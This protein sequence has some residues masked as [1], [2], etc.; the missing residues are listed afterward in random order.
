VT[1][2]NRTDGGRILTV[3][4]ALSVHKRGGR[5]LVLAPDGTGT[6]APPRP[7]IDNAMVK[8]IARAFRWRK[9]LETGVHASIAEIATAEKINDSYVGRVLRLSLLAPEIVE[10]IVE[11]R[12][13]EKLQLAHLLRPFSIEWQSQREA[14]RLITLKS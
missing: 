13:P 11:G 5:K 8:A 9:Q 4:V 14:F 6:M 10:A 12:Q 3:H 2:L 7:R 1:G